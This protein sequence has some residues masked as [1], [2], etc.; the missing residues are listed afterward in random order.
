MEIFESFCAWEDFVEADPESN[1]NNF[2]SDATW[3]GLRRMLLG[4]IGLIE[5]YVVAKGYTIIPRRTLSDPAE[6]HFGVLQEASGLTNNP[7]AAMADALDD[8]A[9]SYVLVEN[10]LKKENE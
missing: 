3:K 7:T 2:L 5:A 4:Y 1:A 9:E 10:A 6:H 8:K